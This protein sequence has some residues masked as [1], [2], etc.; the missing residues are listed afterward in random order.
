M[1]RNMGRLLGLAF[2]ATLALWV[3]VTIVAVLSPSSGTAKA[4]S[5]FGILAFGAFFGLLG[6][7]LME[8]ISSLQGAAPAATP[9]AG[10]A[11]RTS[12]QG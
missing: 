11:P 9:P 2:F 4:A 7:F 1:E 10:D 8:R 3:I 6:A 12:F 5:I